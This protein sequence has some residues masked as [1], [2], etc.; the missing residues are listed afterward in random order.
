M[1]L[2]DK[3]VKKVG[4]PKTLSREVTKSSQKGIREGYTRATFNVSEDLLEKIKALAYWERKEIKEVVEE[5]FNKHLEGK[6]I[7]PIPQIVGRPY[8]GA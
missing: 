6:D 2:P 8:K 7:K 4:R 5:A 1:E 3:K